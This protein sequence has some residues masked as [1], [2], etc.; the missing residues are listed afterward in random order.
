MPSARRRLHC[1]LLLAATLL[2]SRAHGQSSADTAAVYTRAA[3]AAHTEGAR[4][5]A[6]MQD[7]GPMS[8][9]IR[10]AIGAAVHLRTDGGYVADALPHCPKSEIVRPE[11]RGFDLVPGPVRIAGPFAVARVA[12]ACRTW[13]G[14][15]AFWVRESWVAMVAVGGRWWQVFTWHG[16][17]RLAPM[18][19]RQR[20]QS[21]GMRLTPMT[22]AWMGTAVPFLVVLL[23][24]LAWVGYRQA[25]EAAAVAPA[26]RSRRDRALL[27]WRARWIGPVERTLAH[28]RPRLRDAFR[29]VDAALGSMTAAVRPAQS[30][31][32]RIDPAPRP[33][34]PPEAKGTMLARAR[35]AW[36]IAT[37]ALLFAVVRLAIQEPESWRLLAALTYSA[38]GAPVVLGVGLAQAAAMTAL[39]F[40]GPAGAVA[41][42]VCGALLGAAAHAVCAPWLYILPSVGTMIFGGALYGGLVAI[43]PVTPPAAEEHPSHELRRRRRAG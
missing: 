31:G 33:A 12:R 15:S 27:S 41:S 2:P 30:P 13:D 29:A 18:V 21:P 42:I 22:E 20:Y 36:S 19:W 11:E 43:V 1:G 40:R 39:P 14:A 16:G 26:D 7:Y 34:P 28:W 35:V 10:A 6:V 9:T 17:E 32:N 37:V 5:V 24:V 25:R 4:R 8:P 38:M 3:Q 23:L